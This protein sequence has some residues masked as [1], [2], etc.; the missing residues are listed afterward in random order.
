MTS[1]TTPPRKALPTTDAARYL[2]VSAS[3]LRKMR[4]RGSED[5]LGPGPAFIKL[6]PSLI[7]YPIAELD[8]WLDGHARRRSSATCQQ[9]PCHLR[10][11]DR[12]QQAEAIRRLI[13]SDVPEHIAAA[14]SGLSIERV[15]RIL[16]EHRHNDKGAGR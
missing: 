10:L 2:G 1:S 13:A 7:V 6:S 15:R 11:L 5:P 9:E 4:S 16:A 14:A 12:D 8:A 3:L